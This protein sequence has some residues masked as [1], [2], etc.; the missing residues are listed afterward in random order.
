[1]LRSGLVLAIEERGRGASRLELIGGCFTCS[2]ELEFFLASAEFRVY[3]P[4]PPRKGSPEL[5][6]LYWLATEEVG[7]G[8]EEEEEEDSL[9]NDCVGTAKGGLVHGLTSK[10]GVGG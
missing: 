6:L 1:M 3:P 10:R 9:G 8:G 2:R 4:L 5:D 7:W